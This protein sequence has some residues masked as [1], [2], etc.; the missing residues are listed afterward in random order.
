MAHYDLAISVAMQWLSTSKKGRIKLSLNHHKYPNRMEREAMILSSFAGLL[1]NS[2]PVEDVF[3][4]YGSKPS[5]TP[6]QNSA[7]GHLMQPFSLSLHPFAMLTAPQAAQHAIKHCARVYKSTVRNEINSPENHVLATDEEIDP[8]RE[9]T[10]ATSEN[11]EDTIA[12]AECDL[13]S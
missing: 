4:I 7:K 5:T 9:E 10:S 2:I 8:G 13:N 3:E 12:T 1:M 11:G 6:L